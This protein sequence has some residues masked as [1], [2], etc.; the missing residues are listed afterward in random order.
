MNNLKPMKI[1]S[2]PVDDIKGQ[3]IYVSIGEVAKKKEVYYLKTDNL[4]CLDLDAREET[5]LSSE[6]NDVI[7]A[8]YMSTHNKITVSTTKSIIIV[9]CE[10]KAFYKRD[11]DKKIKQVGWN[12]TYDYLAIVFEG[13][14]LSTFVFD[15]RFELMLQGEGS[16]FATIP[17]TEGIGWGSSS[18][19]FQ[20]PV[21]DDELQSIGQHL[22]PIDDLK[23]VISWRGNSDE[24][25]VSYLNEGVR[26]F[27]IFDHL[28]KPKAKSDLLI[29]K[30]YG[31]IAWKPQGNVIAAAIFLDQQNYIGLF[32]KNGLFRMLFCLVDIY[33]PIS[34]LSWS[35]CGK[36]LSVT[37]EDN[38]GQMHI[39]LYTT[40]NYRWYLKQH[41]VFPRTNSLCTSTWA[42]TSPHCVE[43]HTV[44]KNEFIQYK[45]RFDFDVDHRNNLIAAID[46][47]TILVHGLKESVDLSPICTKKI[48]L[49]NPINILAL[50]P[51]KDLA[52]AL[53]SVNILYCYSVEG[54]DLNLMFQINLLNPVFPLNISHLF[55]KGD[56]PQIL[57]ETSQ[58]CFSVLHEL[59]KS[60][61]NL[62]K[63]YDVTLFSIEH[64]YAV[65]NT[66]IIH[67]AK[68]RTIYK[69]NENPKTTP[70]LPY[71]LQVIPL[72]Y[73]GEI[74]CLMLTPEQEFY[75]EEELV[76]RGITSMIVHK[77]YLLLTDNSSLYTLK[78]T[79]H[80]IETLAMDG[81]SEFHIRPLNETANLICMV[82]NTANV[83][84]LTPRGNLEI[85]S[86]RSM[87]VR[88]IE[89]K[90]QQK[91]WSGAIKIMRLSRLNWNLLLDLNADRFYENL[92]AIVTECNSQNVLNSIVSEI[93]DENCLNTVYRKAIE[94]IPY[95][96][97][98]KKKTF[99]NK[100]TSYL[101]ESG[102]FC[103]YLTTVLKIC[104]D[105]NNLEKAMKYMSFLLASNS[106]EDLERIEH[107]LTL[108]KIHI[109]ADDLFKAALNIFDVELADF[110]AKR[111]QMNPLEVDP[112]INELAVLE[113]LPRRI[114]IHLRYQNW[115][116]AIGY[117]MRRENVDKEEVL[118]FIKQHDVSKRAYL[119]SLKISKVPFHKDIVQL[120]VQELVSHKCHNEAA[121]ILVQYCFYN[122]AVTQFKLALDYRKCEEYFP[123]TT[124]NDADKMKIFKEIAEKLVVM[125]KLSEAAFVYE[126][127]LQDHMT[128]V[129][130]LAQGRF[131]VEALRIARKYSYYDLIDLL[132]LPKMLSSLSTIMGKVEETDELFRKK[133]ER[134]KKLRSLKKY[135]FDQIKKRSCYRDGSSTPA[136]SAS[137][138]SRRLHILEKER[139]TEFDSFFAQADAEVQS[140]I[141]VGSHKSS[142]SSSSSSTITQKHIRKLEKQK[143]DTTE[144]SHYEDIA[145]IRELHIMIT[146]IFKF[147]P[148]VRELFLRLL[149]YSVIDLTGLKFQHKKLLDLQQMMKDEMRTIWSEDFKADSNAP[150]ISENFNVIDEKFRAVPPEVVNPGFSWTLEMLKE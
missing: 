16:I 37:Q 82:D 148:E 56:N 25:V 75:V 62:V 19:Q 23:S 11:F 107:G 24:F 120:Y 20:G 105:Q 77:D 94:I 10:T 47:K 63:R 126:D 45:Y 34:F 143:Q 122:E 5:V 83:V 80:A 131:F 124:F 50:H 121:V 51:S 127:Y 88:L 1:R 14:I 68:Y 99:L 27:K 123:L 129:K 116:E 110:I 12:N 29:G 87:E 59:N 86:C 144:G 41:L 84:L 7:R 33:F 3:I 53:D 64:I 149:E 128:A 119:E 57:V 97:L 32:E 67:D 138:S 102:V 100:L 18:T 113:E 39:C 38:K 35:F 111:C 36:V 108:L 145:L 95:T 9:D 55:W 140:V 85:I 93:S 147:G 60:S 135:N 104:L 73:G 49:E 13:G 78:L 40:S 118:N 134:L 141:S 142:R 79:R 103:E 65:D 61:L 26:Q 15:V 4:I 109:N 74:F 8:E 30:M 71:P 130:I 92:A 76:C 44:T 117:M 101:D 21:K 90:L 46:G 98:H 91:D 89:Q 17:Q 70:N 146:L 106:E 58:E 115:E 132:I 2:L 72:K 112:I 137:Y 43:L 6:I 96:P 139:A 42:I 66:I 52:A 69:M 81:L 136:S 22:P 48:L 31:P 54:I 28:C 133:L 150:Y 125:E 114:A